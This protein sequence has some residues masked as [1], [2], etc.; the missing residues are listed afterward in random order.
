[1]A[2]RSKQL[3]NGTVNVGS[4]AVTL[5][6]ATSGETPLLK[7]VTVFNRHASSSATFWLARGTGASSTQDGVFLTETL[8]AGE[9]RRYEVWIVL[10]GSGNVSAIAS[11]SGAISI[12]LYGAELEGVAD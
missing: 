2:V 10:G 12:R 3:T 9:A 1:M 4:S 5:Y 6:T 11:I 8:A 7:Y